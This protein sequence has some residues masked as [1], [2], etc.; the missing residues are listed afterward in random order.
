MKRAGWLDVPETGGA[1]AIRFLVIV[2]TVFGRAPARA[3]LRL[4]AAYY[5]LTHRTSREA[6]RNWLQRV[7]GSGRVTTRMVY[8]HILCFAQVSLDRLFLVR[9]QL[10]RFDLRGFGEEHLRAARASKR[11]VIFLGAHLGAFEALCALAETDDVRVNIVGYFGNAKRIN[12]AL[13]RIAPRGA[14]RLIEIQ[15]GTVEFVF[16]IQDCIDRGEHVGILGDRVG[17]GGDTIE[18]DFMGAPARFPSGVYGLASVLR[19]PVYLVF[20]LYTKP[21]RYD[22]HCE[23]FAERVVLPRNGRST[24]LAEYAKRYAGRLEH[25]ARMAPENWFNFFDFWSG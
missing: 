6:S 14:V 24:A 5:T 23:P 2:C 18:V 16:T 19:C 3:F 12:A 21:N 13:R 4:V 25:Y 20:G 22:I 7:H 15:P 11:G 9:G 1:F 10:W 8:S 17:L